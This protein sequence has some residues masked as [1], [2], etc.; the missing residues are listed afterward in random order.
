MWCGPLNPLDV[1]KEEIGNKT[2]LQYAASLG[3]LKRKG[4]KQNLFEKIEMKFFIRS[5]LIL[6]NYVGEW[7]NLNKIMTQDIN[8]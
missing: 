2:E 3:N 8:E 4:F 5:Y 6:P 7:F 1:V